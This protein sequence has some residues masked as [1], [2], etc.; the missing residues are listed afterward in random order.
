MIY[1]YYSENE[2]LVKNKINELV[3]Y[4]EITKFDMNDIKLESLHSHILTPNLFGDLNYVLCSNFKLIENKVKLDEIILK[5][6]SDIANSVDSYLLIKIN[7]TLNKANPYVAHLVGNY[8][9]FEIS[10]SKNNLVNSIQEFTMKEDINI[11]KTNIEFLLDLYDNDFNLTKLEIQK[12][13]LIEIGR[14]I[15]IITIENYAT[16]NSKTDIWKLTESILL[17]DFHKANMMIKELID[18]GK[19]I[20]EIVALYHTQLKFYYEVKILSETQSYKAIASTLKLHEYRVKMA[21]PLVNKVSLI[22]IQ[23]QFIKLSNLDFDIKTGRV[24]PEIAMSLFLSR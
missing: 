6:I 16:K 4:D 5:Q 15:D 7:K 17:N 3:N 9:Y 13:S 22:N 18:S 14:E 12:L 23:T 8:E 10:A 11:N 19:T 21:I 1:F 24:D 2:E 20:Y